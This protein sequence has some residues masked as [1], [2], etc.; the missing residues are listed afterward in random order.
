MHPR[1]TRL[2]KG[3]NMKLFLTLSL[4]L[5]FSFSVLAQSGAQSSSSINS[6]WNKFK[7]KLSMSFFSVY[8]GPGINN[9]GLNT[10]DSN[11]NVL[12]DSYTSNWLQL[13]LRY[14]L[15]DSTRL[16]FNPR[17]SISHS[18]QAEDQYQLLNPVVG[19]TTTW[20]KRGDWSFT[21]GLNTIFLPV[22]TSTFQNKLL[23]NPGGFNSLNYTRPTWSA[24]LWVWGRGYL[25]DSSIE[26]DKMNYELTLSPYYE[27]KVKDSMTVRAFVDQYFEQQTGK[28]FGHVNRMDTLTAGVGL[29]TMITKSVGIYP[30]LKVNATNKFSVDTTSIAAWI[31]GSLF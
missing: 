12:K 1:S 7:D 22:Q 28:A 30:H 26:E 23:A 19:F 17:F 27:Y 13:S 25:H 29:D 9:V 6:T 15:T 14:Q 20:W 4:M 3:V 2:V 21:G 18:S 31:Y 24:G 11:G 5:T 10:I 8:T 16:V